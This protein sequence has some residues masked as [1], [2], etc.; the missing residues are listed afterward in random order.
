MSFA[1]TL[2]AGDSYAFRFP[3]LEPKPNAEVW[4]EGGGTG[5]IDAYWADFAS[6]VAEGKEADEDAFLNDRAPDVVRQRVVDLTGWAV[7]AH[8]R[9]GA[10][11]ISDLDVQ[12]ETAAFGG[13]VMTLPAEQTE[14][15][16]A[17][18]Y[19]AQ[20][21]FSKDNKVIS[22]DVIKITVQKDVTYA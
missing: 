21:E 14:T 7:R 6:W 22:S 15:W 3:A 10:T 11:K 9:E 17:K 20:I 8:M 2:K 4:A 13:L 18:T 12:M 5:G 1:L 19:D 16:E